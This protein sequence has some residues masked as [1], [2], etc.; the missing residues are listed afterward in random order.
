MEE[1][2][3]IFLDYD[4]SQSFVLVEKNKKRQKERQRKALKRVVALALLLVLI[5][6]AIKLFPYM[7]EL[8][9][10]FFEA[11]NSTTTPST[12][13]NGQNGNEGN[14]QNGTDNGIIDTNTDTL[15]EKNEGSTDTETDTKSNEDNVDTSTDDE[16][17]NDE[18]TKEGYYK[19]NEVGASKYVAINESGCE[20][21]FSIK[22]SKT[23]LD[24]IYRKYGND[25]PVVLITHSLVTEA[26]SNGKSY[27]TDDNFY[28]ENEN[29]GDIG[30]VICERLNALGIG[31]IQLNE[32]YASGAIHSSQAEYK[33]SLEETLKK[34][35]SISYV[36]NIS[37]GTSINDDLTMN[38]SYITKNGEK[39]AQISLTSGT[40]WDTAS[41]EQI[42][43]VRFAFDFS[44]FINK[45]TQNFVKENVISRYPLAQNIS[46]LVANVDIGDYSNSFEEARRSAELF[47]QLIY[48][49]ISD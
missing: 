46:P 40:N 16:N 12:D 4:N 37:R 35:P 13:N 3:M 27:S 24:E 7:K 22:F 18:S 39:Y 11:K 14:N 33:K 47:A 25:S 9:V 8:V 48:E 10:D 29:V 26:Y 2:D 15:P 44:K 5:F 30:E 6:G 32:L 28:A 41:S 36:F 45:N 17:S 34:Y 23:T 49:Y 38:K 21:D 20:F 42:E 43:N 1:K 19:I 31:A